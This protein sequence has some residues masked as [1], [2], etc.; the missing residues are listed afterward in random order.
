MILCNLLLLMT[1]GSRTIKQ[2]ETDGIFS[3]LILNSYTLNLN[4]SEHLDMIS[5]DRGNI[6]PLLPIILTTKVYTSMTSP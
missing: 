4:P 1:T 3:H 6:T 2:H 5:C